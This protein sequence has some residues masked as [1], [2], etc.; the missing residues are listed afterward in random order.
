M[1]FRSRSI[2]DLYGEWLGDSWQIS[3]LRTTY[4][5]L[6]VIPIPLHSEK[7]ATRGFNQAELIARSFC[8]VTGHKLD[9]SLHRNRSTVAQFGLS[10]L[11]R[12]ENVSGA[13]SIDPKS[14]LKPGMTVLLVDDIY[15][16][17]ATVRAATDVL[18]IRQINVC[19]VAV[20]AT[21]RKLGDRE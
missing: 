11:A 14:S 7:L 13:F 19:G 21:G 16:T 17:G 10:K 4:P 15:T 3:Q 12:Q 1:L 6:I 18:R 8:Q 20:V 5:K 9:V 2:A